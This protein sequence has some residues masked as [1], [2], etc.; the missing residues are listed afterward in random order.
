MK[1]FSDMEGYETGAEHAIWSKRVREKKAS[2]PR[3]ARR[4]IGEP[5]VEGRWV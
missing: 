2:Q 5:E 3:T 1:S 4:G